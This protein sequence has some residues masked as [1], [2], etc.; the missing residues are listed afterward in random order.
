[1][2]VGICGLGKRMAYVAKCFAEHAPYLRL[3]AYAD[4]AP[5]G[6]SYLEARGISAGRPYATL[7][8]MLDGES[9]D[10]LMVGSPNHLHLDHIAAGLDCG[11]KVFCEKPVV[12]TEEQTVGVLRL[13][14][15]HGTDAVM[16]GLVLRYSPLY[17]DLVAA[18]DGGVLG[19][20][21]SIEASEHITPDHGAFF[22]RDW[23]RRSDYSGGFSLG[24]V[25]P[26]PRPVSGRRRQPSGARGQLRRAPVPS[27]RVIASARGDPAYH[28]MSAGWH[29]APSVFEGDGDIV[30]HQTALIEYAN[31][32][33]LCLSHQ[34]ERPGGVSGISAS[35][36]RTPRPRAI[37][38]AIS[39][40]CARRAPAGSERTVATRST[41][42]W[43]TTARKN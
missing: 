33:N 42:P 23:R 36:A 7:E 26:R 37:S 1:M 2:K 17:R 30:D 3:V 18:V 28:R 35:S 21:S 29:G 11:L 8:A 27:W 31:G 6:L 34:P 13:L 24:E 38:S 5:V 39:S 40:V 15:K 22:M 14:Q 20:I 10:L 25:L 4:L 19:C 12:T 43:A 32:V 16:V 9:L 41:I